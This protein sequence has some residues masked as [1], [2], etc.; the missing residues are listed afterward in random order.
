MSVTDFYCS[1]MASKYTRYI[2]CPPCF[3]VLLQRDLRSGVHPQSTRRNGR[4]PGH[5]CPVGL[6]TNQIVAQFRKPIQSVPDATLGLLEQ[7]YNPRDTSAASATA[8]GSVYSRA[9]LPRSALKLNCS[10]ANLPTSP[11][12]QSTAP[13]CH[14]CRFSPLQNEWRALGNVWVLARLGSH[15]FPF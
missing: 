6:Q 5:Q 8:S 9:S 7:L 1:Q 10:R 12:R 4:F 15:P 14:A 2:H 13:L 11:I 3:A